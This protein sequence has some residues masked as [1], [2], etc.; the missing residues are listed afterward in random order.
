MVVEAKLWD[1]YIPGRGIHQFSFNKQADQNVHG[2]NLRKT[3]GF[4]LQGLTIP[5][6]WN[7]EL[8]LEGQRKVFLCCMCKIMQIMNTTSSNSR[9]LSFLVL[10]RLCPPKD[11]Q[12]GRR[13]GK[14]VSRFCGYENGSREFHLKIKN[15]T[16]AEGEASGAVK[17]K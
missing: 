17:K 10:A 9:I 6:P 2:R 1:F 14:V 16:K 8:C 12:N 5:W 7:I 11:V 3:L 15:E 13:K 4:F